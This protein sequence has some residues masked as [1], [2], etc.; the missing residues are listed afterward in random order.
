MQ[1]LL[2]AAPAWLTVLYR[3]DYRTEVSTPV[4]AQ[5]FPGRRSNRKIPYL[6]D[7][8]KLRVSSWMGARL[9]LFGIKGETSI[10]GSALLLLHNC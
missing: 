1:F 7:A 2:T 9:R 4:S 6:S 8:G 5:I 10:R 3:E